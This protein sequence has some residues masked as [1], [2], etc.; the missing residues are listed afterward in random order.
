MKLVSAIMPTRGRQQWAEQAL[1]SFLGQTYPDKELIILDDMDDRSFARFGVLPP[2]ENVIYRLLETRETIPQK[3]NHA[4]RIANGS[5]IVHWDSDDHSAPTR[6]EDQVRRLEQSGKAV[7]GYHSM[8]FFDEDGWRAYHYTNNPEY[9]VGTSLAYLK[10][11][12]ASHPFNENL[13]AGEDNEAVH[14]ARKEGQLVTADAAALMVA[15][16]HG[17]NTDR[18]NI[19]PGQLNFRQVP[20][21]LIPKAFFGGRS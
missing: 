12:W 5:I 17:G 14:A 11:W 9:A 10:S 15:R 13:R 4:C 1:E 6:L 20:I 19:A 18:K 2:P 8:L 16:I 7:T 3:R 21:D